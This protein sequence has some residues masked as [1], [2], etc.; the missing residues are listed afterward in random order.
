MGFLYMIVYYLAALFSA[1]AS[2]KQEPQYSRVHIY[3]N[4]HITTRRDY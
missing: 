2:R 3:T 4:D 1:P